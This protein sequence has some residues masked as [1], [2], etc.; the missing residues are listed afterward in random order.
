[1]RDPPGAAGAGAVGCP[2]HDA[3]IRAGRAGHALQ[4]ERGRKPAQQGI[5][6][7]HAEAWLAA[8]RQWRSLFLPSARS[9]RHPDRPQA[10]RRHHRGGAAARHH[11]GHRRHPR[12]DRPDVRRGHRPPG[13]GPDQDRQARSRV[14]EGRAGGEPA[15]AAA[16]DLRRHPRAPGQARRPA[17]QHAHPRVH[18]GGGARAHRRGDAGDLCAARRAHGHARHARGA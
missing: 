8:A 12:R 1:M 4:S 17:A 15:Q 5:R 3:P 16:G 9:R 6:V 2:R 10:G 7:C 11:R 14:E 13:R 18:A